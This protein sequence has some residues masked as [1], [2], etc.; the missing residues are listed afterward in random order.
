MPGCSLVVVVVVVVAGRA[1]RQFQRHQEQ[2]CFSWSFLSKCATSQSLQTLQQFALELL[3]SADRHKHTHTHRI[4][5]RRQWP[6]HCLTL[7]LLNMQILEKA[8]KVYIH[9][10]SAGNCRLC[11]CAAAAAAAVSAALVIRQVAIHFILLLSF[12]FLFFFLCFILSSD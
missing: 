12:P 4:A 5:R 1:T 3:S 6:A 2:T 7:S 11:V 8:A 9:A 10:H